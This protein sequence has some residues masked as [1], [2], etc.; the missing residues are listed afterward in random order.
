[1][2]KSIYQ[3]ALKS[4]F[5]RQMAR[6]LRRTIYSACGIGDSF[7]DIARLSQLSKATSFLDIGC[8]HGYTMLRY[9]ESGVTCP[10]VGFDPMEENI[11]V[12]RKALR[13]KGNVQFVQAALSEK[14]EDRDFFVNANIQTSSLLENDC[15]NRESLPEETQL[16]QI[17]KLRT[18]SLDQWAREAP[19]DLS[20]VIVKCDVQG[21]EAAVVRG[22]SRLFKENVIGFFGEVQLR[23][24]YA[25][26]ATL[27]ELNRLLEEEHQ[28]VLYNIYSCLRDNQGRALQAD[29][30]WVKQP[31]LSQLASLAS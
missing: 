9:I 2:L 1:M 30:L 22:G 23:K 11:V 4:T 18:L 13:G 31:W 6:G 7:Y 29:A 16:K 19:A 27:E 8:H 10:M 21:A 20:R 15:G 12:A 17:L 5:T 24:M 26:Q 25:G 28:L 14:D 3:Q